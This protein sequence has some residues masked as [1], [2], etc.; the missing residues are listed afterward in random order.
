M[1]RARVAQKRVKARQPL[2]DARRARRTSARNAQYVSA[3]GV[4]AEV[5]GTPVPPGPCLPYRQIQSSGPSPC[6]Q[7]A[8]EV[9]I[10]LP[11]A[12]R[13]R[14]LTVSYCRAERDRFVAE[15]QALARP[16]LIGLEPTGHY[17]RPLAWRLVQAGFDVRLVSSVALARTQEA[18]HNGWDKKTRR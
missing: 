7:A 2:Y 6:G 14:R 9:L 5:S 8:Q 13:R 3:S 1:R 17:H 18:L 12:R 4:P 11:E 10:E 16:V 15:L